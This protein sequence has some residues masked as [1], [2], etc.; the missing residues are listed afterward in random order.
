[1]ID[2][3]YSFWDIDEDMEDVPYDGSYVEDY[4][5]HLGALFEYADNEGY[6]VQDIFTRLIK[7][8]F[9]YYLDICH[10]HYIGGCSDY[11]FTKYVL[12][13]TLGLK[14]EKYKSAS[15]GTDAYWWGWSMALVQWWYNISWDD[16]EKYCK[17]ETAM[18]IYP[19]GHTTD[20]LHI[21]EAY[22]MRIKEAGY[23]KELGDPWE[24]NEYFLSKYGK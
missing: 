24:M 10:P 19:A 4:M 13:D 14:L 21:L 12:C 23:P 17:I 20:N 6:D 2:K 1:M 7:S 8:E 9:K 22:R 15:V 3:R 11:E 18:I 16:M 5:D